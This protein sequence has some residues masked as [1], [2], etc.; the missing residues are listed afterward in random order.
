MTVGAQDGIDGCG[1]DEAGT[2]EAARWH[3]ALRQREALMRIARPRTATAEDAEDVVQE[4]MVR[5]AE[6]YRG[7][8]EGLAPWLM[9]V[10]V[11]L[12]A[13][14]HRQRVREHRRWSRLPVSLDPASFDER[15]CDQA[16][17]AWAAAAMS[18]LPAR[19][20]RALRL[21]AEGLTVLQVARQL[22]VSYRTAES[23]L[24][25]A[26]STLKAVLAATLGLAVVW[27]RWAADA[28]RLAPAYP[29]VAATT[30][31]TAVAVT[32]VIAPVPATVDPTQH[33]R[34]PSV[35]PAE[36]A[37]DVRSTPSPFPFPSVSPSLSP[38]VSSSPAS[39]PSASATPTAAAGRGKA[40][41][42]GKSADKGKS[43]GKGKS[44]DK[45][46]SGDKSKSGD[47]GKSGDKGKPAD[48][49]KPADP[50]K[51]PVAPG[52]TI[53]P[54]PGADGGAVP[55]N[56]LPSLPG[57]AP[58]PADP[59]R[60]GSADRQPRRHQHAALGSGAGMPVLIDTAWSRPC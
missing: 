45:G 51:L 32:I 29:A 56:A 33:H 57:K 4:A 52:L 1:P 7:D 38:S 23:L 44:A 24:A 35:L 11:R 36:T 46:K 40:A 9:R 12:C 18:R 58:A 15:V 49:G 10:T 60:T 41:G 42:K 53:R 47:M 27:W 28:A 5:A 14:T 2:A 3:A 31:A 22:E 54:I 34:R 59:G 39:V 16:E 43:A 19:Q 13:D 17:A 50:G 8:A 25:R 6:S 20:A 30:A 55:P 48:R 37:A 26:R 21:R